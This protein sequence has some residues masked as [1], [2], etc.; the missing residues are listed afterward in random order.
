MILECRDYRGLKKQ[1]A[2]IRKAQETGASEAFDETTR[3]QPTV[4]DVNTNPSRSEA[5]RAPSNYG[6]TG[7]TPPLSGRVHIEIR[8]SSPPPVELPDP[9][10]P[11]PTDKPK[12][13]ASVLTDGSCLSIPPEGTQTR[14]ARQRIDGTVRGL[15]SNALS[16]FDHMLRCPSLRQL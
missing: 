2:A 6:S 5:S 9:A 16:T 1:I 15:Y 7:E 4:E 11:L 13:T 8:S 10:I 12:S 3:S 14:L